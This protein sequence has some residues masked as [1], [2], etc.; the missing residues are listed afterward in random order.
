MATFV[1]RP[2]HPLAS[3]NGFVN[4][5]EAYTYNDKEAVIGNRSVKA[6][7][8]SD[9][10]DA[11]R[12]MCDGKYYDSKQKFRAT[13]KAH[14]CVEVGNEVPVMTRPRK[15]VELDRRQRR[16]DIKRTIYD[17]RNGKR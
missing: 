15:P 11:T 16:D 14:G 1:Y 13:T 5:E 10:M 3:V 12:H 7:V 8:V 6:Y 4:K 17:I 2:D 9:T